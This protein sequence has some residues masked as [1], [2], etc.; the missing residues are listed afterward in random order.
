MTAGTNS[1]F[2]DRA[3][4]RLW[5][6]LCMSLLGACTPVADWQPEGVVEI[7]GFVEHETVLGERVC[8]VALRV[9]NTGKS[10]IRQCTI[11]LSVETDS[12]LYR[13]TSFVE[14]YVPPGSFIWDTVSVRYYDQAE[15]TADARMH[16]DDA[17]FR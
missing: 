3:G 6:L 8:D 7:V 14:V 13:F 10:A 17:F 1:R 15:T 4:S 9:T 16:V 5:V 11:S 12:N 2:V